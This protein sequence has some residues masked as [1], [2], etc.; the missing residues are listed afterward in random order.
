MPTMLTAWIHSADCA[1]AD[2]EDAD[3]DGVVTDEDCDDG[4]DGVDDD[5]RPDN[6]PNI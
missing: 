1:T 3:C 4:N 2:F 5:G 6:D